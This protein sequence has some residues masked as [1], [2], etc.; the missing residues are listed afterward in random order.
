MTAMR[1][2]RRNQGE[3]WNSSRP[4]FRSLE[5]ILYWH[6]SSALEH[7]ERKLQEI[8][9]RVDAAGHTENDEDVQIVSELMDDIRDAVTDFQVG[10]DPKSILRVLHPGNRSRR[11]ANTSYMRKFSN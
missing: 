11:R 5:P 9:N 2:M 4:L 6:L 1:R 10:C 7:I 3:R 8:L